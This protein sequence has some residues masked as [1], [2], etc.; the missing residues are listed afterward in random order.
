MSSQFL[1]ADSDRHCR[2]LRSAAHGSLSVAGSLSF[3][4]GADQFILLHFAAAL[5]IEIARSVQEFLLCPTF[6]VAV[7]IAR[8]GG[9]LLSAFGAAFL[10]A[11]LVHRT[12]SDFFG[13]LGAFSTFLLRFL[14]M[15]ILPLIFFAPGPGHGW[16]LS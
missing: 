1:C 4:N 16:L 13:S 3:A 9:G 7:G 5:D 12:G 8:A 11:F 14:D 2:P 10:A 15:F 6:E